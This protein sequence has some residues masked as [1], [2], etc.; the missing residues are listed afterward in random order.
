MRKSMIWCAVACLSVLST[1]PV[2]GQNINSVMSIRTSTSQQGT[3]IVVA[4]EQVS[5]KQ[6]GPMKLSAQVNGIYMIR[7]SHGA[8]M[9]FEQTTVFKSTKLTPMPSPNST[10]T[11][12]IGKIAP[13]KPPVPVAGAT[14]TLVAATYSDIKVSDGQTGNVGLTSVVTWK[15]GG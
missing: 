10:V 11:S 6:A 14:A 7:D 15:A 5:A 1:S 2:T 9:G 8:Q 12:G 3:L 4:D 13:V